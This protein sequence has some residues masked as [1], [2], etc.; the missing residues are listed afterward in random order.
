[1]NKIGRFKK[2]IEK[3]REGEVIVIDMLGKEY[4]G[5]I[6]TMNENNLSLVLMNN[7]SKILIKNI[8]SIKRYR[9]KIW[10]VN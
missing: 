3:F 9:N 10:Q 1:M 6:L 7:D 8:V 2:E 5:K 4:K